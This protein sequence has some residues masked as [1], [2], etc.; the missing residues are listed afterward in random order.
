MAFRPFDHDETPPGWAANA[1]TRIPPA[2]AVS[3]VAVLSEVGSADTIFGDPMTDPSSN[4]N[5]TRI[6]FERWRNG[7]D[8]AFAALHTRFTPLLRARIRRHRAWPLLANHFEADDVLQEIW[9]RAV[10]AAKSSFC[11]N[12][13]GSLLAFLSRVADREVIDLARRHRAQKRGRGGPASLATGFDAPDATRPGRPAPTTP[14]GHARLSELRAMARTLL[15]D[16]EHEAWDL[17]E[18]QQ[19]S[20]EEAAIAL[21]CSASAVRGLL[22][23]ARAKLVACLSDV[24]PNANRRAGD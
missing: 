23:R 24:P 3:R 10:P 4:D 13:E 14:T 15:S 17:V 7:D 22:L 16:R 18:I 12:G 2:N 11:H 8:E 6:P 21:Q 19:Y 20:A 5:P 9:A 1:S